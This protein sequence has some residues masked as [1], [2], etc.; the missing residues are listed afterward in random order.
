RQGDVVARA[1][2]DAVEAEGA[3]HV[4]RLARLVQV[5]L[6]AGD[7]IPAAYA[8]L[9]AAGGADFRV[10]D[11]HLQWRNQGLHEV[12]LADRAEVLAE[13][14]PAEGAIDDEGRREVAQGEPGG[15]PGTVPE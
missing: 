4:A 6:T 2:V 15:P 10:A 14:R 13:R 5:Q 7:A 11:L 9:R 3:V 12:E 1:G 8:V